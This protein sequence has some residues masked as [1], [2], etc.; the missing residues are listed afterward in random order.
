VYADPTQAQV[1][2]TGRGAVRLAGINDEEAQFS[3][4]PPTKGQDT[5]LAD[6]VKPL[7]QNKKAETCIRA[8]GMLTWPGRAIL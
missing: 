1:A 6:F 5:S 2:I 4:P 8:F 7:N 3:Y